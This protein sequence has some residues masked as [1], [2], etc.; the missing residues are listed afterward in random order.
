MASLRGS[1]EDIVFVICLIDIEGSLILRLVKE[2][3]VQKVPRSSRQS[4]T[5]FLY[6]QSIARKQWRGMMS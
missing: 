3:E 5:V 2:V 6:R 4:Y 1:F